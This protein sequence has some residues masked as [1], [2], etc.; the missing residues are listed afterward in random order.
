MSNN[1]DKTRVIRKQS[2]TRLVRKEGDTAATQKTT[3]P[4][5]EP[6]TKVLSAG[7]ISGD[8]T[9]DN[10]ASSGAYI[11]PN[12]GP[13]VGWLVVVDGPGRGQFRGIYNGVNS[14]GRGD[15]QRIC[16]N[17]GD[18]ALSR[19]EH[20]TIIFDEKTSIFYLERGKSANLLRLNGDAVIGQ[21]VLSDGNELYL[22]ETKVR[23]VA[24]CGDD[25][26]WTEQVEKG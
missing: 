16:L 14:I 22:G 6:K 25:F 15:D 20:A 2:T 19:T 1:D 18:E 9:G 3:S 5:A 10:G 17:F 24:L 4:A 8:T 21:P 7:S 12:S 13:V 11:D 26:S 23:F